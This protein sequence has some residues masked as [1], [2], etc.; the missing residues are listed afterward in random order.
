MI[1]NVDSTLKE[2][3]FEVLDKP[4]DTEL[5]FSFV[6]P[7]KEWLKSAATSKNWI[8]IYLLEIRE[9]TELRR[10]DESQKNYSADKVE[11]KKQ[12][13]YVDLYYLVTFYNKEG[14][15]AQEHKYLESVLLSL[16]DFPN[17]VH[18][19]IA[20]TTLLKQI[21]LEL[22]P[23]PFIDEQLGYQL[24]SA[25]DQDA[26]PYIPIKVTVPL[27]SAVVLQS[28]AIVQ[29]KKMHYEVLN[30]VLYRLQGR[31]VHQNGNVNNPVAGAVLKIKDKGG[32]IISQTA[33]NSMGSFEF[34]QLK[35]E[36]EMTA[37]VEAEG[38]VSKEIDLE[39]IPQ[40]SKGSVTIVLEKA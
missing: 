30:G 25:L 17:R 23:K 10:N 2:Y 19:H 5:D 29:N 6:L 39:N 24:W 32:E 12:P 38:Y 22:F 26:R 11:K 33:T 16:Y 4:S 28:D 13:L 20:D 27:V 40:M 31:V 7:N 35:H 18:D 1:E 8:N 3:L 21:T 9:N 37:S 15:S 36:E 34:K 14:S